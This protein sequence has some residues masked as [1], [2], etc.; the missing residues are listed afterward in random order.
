MDH[1]LLRYERNL[2]RFSRARKKRLGK[3]PLLLAKFLQDVLVV[4][5][6]GLLAYPDV[7]I[8]T[9]QRTPPSQSTRSFWKAV[10]VLTIDTGT[11]LPRFPAVNQSL[12]RANYTQG[13]ASGLAMN[14]FLVQ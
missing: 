5:E 8:L 7:I 4:S 14:P 13:V 10:P 2:T 11:R 12:L 1:N 9:S 3:S 6:S